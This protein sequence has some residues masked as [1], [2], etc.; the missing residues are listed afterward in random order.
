MRKMDDT[1]KG[2]GTLNSTSSEVKNACH[3]HLKVMGFVEVKHEEK[4]QRELEG[5]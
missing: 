1:V 2:S 4:S 3:P 5:A